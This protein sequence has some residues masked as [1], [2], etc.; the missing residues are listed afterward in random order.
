MTERRRILFVDDEPAILEGF[1]NLLYRDRKR[2][3]LAFVNCGAAALEAFDKAPFDVVVTDL[4]MPGMDGAAL[5]E[6]IKR[7]SPTTARIML[8]GHAERSV[9]VRALPSLHQLIAKPCTVD[10]LRSAI[11]RSLELGTVDRD[12]RVRAAIGRVDKLP[13]PPPLF[14]EL[15]QLMEAKHTSID[16][17]AALIG[18]DP[19]IATKVLQLVNSA[20]FG[21]GG[22]TNSIRQAIALLGMEGLRY[23]AMAAHVFAPIE[24]PL[25]E[26]TVGEL[27]AEGFVT[28]SLAAQFAPE[29]P[30]SAFA[31]GLLHDVGRLVLLLGMTDEYRTVL[32]RR[33]VTK[34]PAIAVENEMLGFDHAE[35]GAVLLSLWGL[36]TDLVNVVRAHHAPDTAP[37]H[38]RALASAVHVADAYAVGCA[39]DEEALERAGQRH[40]LA[41]WRKLAERS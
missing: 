36:P 7:R 18:R 2:W 27:Q 28:A 22:K 13:S 11:E 40:K 16:N 29:T 34:E 24:D 21:A 20:Y 17:V 10:A 26:L 38:L 30:D 23:L 32:R 39:V 33:A 35:V 31:A 37:A 6:E 4:M 12:A 3:E 5:L 1:G 14:F 19:G 15:T 9:I 25:K 8:S 41:G